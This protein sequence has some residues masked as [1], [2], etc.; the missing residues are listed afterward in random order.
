M[1][2]RIIAGTLEQE[3]GDETAK[4]VMDEYYSLVAAGESETARVQK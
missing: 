4:K 1:A 2:T 3:G